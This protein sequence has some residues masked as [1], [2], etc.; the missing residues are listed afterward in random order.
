MQLKKET[1][2]ESSERN[3]REMMQE[4]QLFEFID[5]IQPRD[6]KIQATMKK[7]Q[8]I[9]DKGFLLRSCMLNQEKCPETMIK[10]G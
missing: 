5:L 4:L 2:S 6:E 9:K 8:E 3:K 7:R 10:F 1:K